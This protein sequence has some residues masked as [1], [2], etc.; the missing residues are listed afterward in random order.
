MTLKIR[1]HLAPQPEI[2]STFYF[3]SQRLC[4]KGFFVEASEFDQANVKS[5][6]EYVIDSVTPATVEP[7]L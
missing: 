5:G 7:L 3:S 1:S 4:V 6:F 2:S